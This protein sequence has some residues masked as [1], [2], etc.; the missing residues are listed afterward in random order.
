MQFLK[1]KFL[2][3]ILFIFF[4]SFYVKAQ[5]TI[6]VGRPVD[7]LSYQKDF[8]DVIKK[9]FPSKKPDTA[10]KTGAVTVLP[11]IGYNP[12]IGFLLGINFLKTFNMGDPSTTKLS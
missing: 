8:I 4:I 3:C 11:A 7:S 10:K 9:I 12:S 6:V 5:D 1:Q 2:L